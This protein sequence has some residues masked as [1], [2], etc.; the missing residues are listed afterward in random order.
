[1]PVD[2]LR[3]YLEENHVKYVTV[4]HSPAFTAQEIAASAHVPGKE[5]AKTVMVKV[6]GEMLMV[7]LPATER[8]DLELLREATGSKK[9]ELAREEEFTKLFPE[10]ERGAM[11]PF[12][13]LWNMKTLVDQQL[14]EDE[15]IAFNAGTLTELI[16]LSYSDY[17]RL[18][19]P[20]VLKIGIPA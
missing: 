6:D 11:P 1:M 2:R 18:V 14:R 8:I 20:T 5:L 19:E 15:R 13:N 7:V 16:Q 17:E 4:S 9:V 3:K 10:C 12:G